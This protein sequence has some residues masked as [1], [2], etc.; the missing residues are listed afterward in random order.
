M[1]TR[2]LALSA[3]SWGRARAKLYLPKASMPL[4]IFSS[5]SAS[6][7]PCVSLS[8]SQTSHH[9]S[10]HFHDEDFAAQHTI[11]PHSDQT[12]FLKP[13]WL[14]FFSSFR[15]SSLPLPPFFSQ[16]KGSHLDFLKLVNYCGL[17]SRRVLHKQKCY[18]N[19]HISLPAAWWVI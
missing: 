1:R 2:A 14:P 19:F 15:P 11:S 17:L 12:F 4:S 18:S 8:F 16:H 6:T 9:Y 7:F 10:S 13:Y 5:L 3:S